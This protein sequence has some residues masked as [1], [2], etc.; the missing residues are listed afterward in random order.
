MRT[1]PTSR[2]LRLTTAALAL[3]TSPLLAQDTG[4]IYLLDEIIVS[5][6]LIPVAKSETGATVETVGE[7][8]LSTPSKTVADILDTLPGISVSKNGGIGASATLRIRGLG[9]EYIGVR[10]NGIDITDPSAPQS[11]YD[12]GGLRSYGIA[13]AEVVKGS[14]S[15]LYG[16]EAIAGLVEMNTTPQT[17]GL[18]ATLEA[19]SYDTYSAGVTNMVESEKGHIAF[20]LS[21]FKTDGFSSSSSNDEDDGF[22]ETFLTFGLEHDIN[23]SLTLGLTGFYRDS[24]LEYDTD[25]DI[26]A[27][28]TREQKGVRTYA[29]FETAQISHEL[30]ASFFQSDR[31]YGSGSSSYYYSSERKEV[32]YLGSTDLSASTTLTFGAEYLE[33][34]YDG[35][36]GNGIDRNTALKGEFLFEPMAGLNL[37]AALRYD[38]HSDLGENISGRLAAAWEVAPDW[39]LRAVLGTGFRAPSLSERFGYGGD[40]DFKEETSRSAELS[41]ER[42]FMGDDFVKATLFYTE[43]DDKI[44]YNYDTW[45]YEQIGGTTTSQ[46][47]ELSGQY[48]LSQRVTLFGSYTYTDSENDGA[49]ATR[50]PR[51]DVVAGLDTTLSDRLSGTFSVQHV[52]DLLDTSTRLDDY[53]LFNASLS[54]DLTDTVQLYLRADN[55]TDEDYETASGY[56]TPGRS[57]YLGLKASF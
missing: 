37:S 46:G 30:S 24:D 55:L 34:S 18:S 42:R 20:S 49:R 3:T 1:R 27:T 16:S 32:S 26:D 13:S 51:H 40:P 57:A 41:V 23:D 33:E 2:L 10:L 31:T 15:A 14:Q 36:Y 17:P 35:T 5:G 52:A 44:N 43:I 54:Y 22:E 47:V 9:S 29:Q 48:R 6:S 45:A 8:S 12:F 28:A 11:A 4:E 7:D 56:N 21:H 39:T 38:D 19:G 53:T 50:V 25:W